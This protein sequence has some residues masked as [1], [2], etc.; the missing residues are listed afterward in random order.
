MLNALRQITSAAFYFKIMSWQKIGMILM[1]AGG[2][3]TAL[4]IT[5]PHLARLET[6]LE[7][8]ASL[9]ILG[10]IREGK[11]LNDVPTIDDAAGMLAGFLARISILF[12]LHV[13]QQR[14][15]RGNHLITDPLHFC[16]FFLLVFAGTIAALVLSGLLIILYFALFCLDALYWLIMAPY[17]AGVL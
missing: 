6:K 5:G 17:K 13:D 14:R 11:L 15:W 16:L 7:K 9:N 8:L 10:S 12:V 4:D 1:S 3:S 2:I